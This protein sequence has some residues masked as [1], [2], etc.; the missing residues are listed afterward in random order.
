VVVASQEAVMTDLL[1]RN[2]IVVTSDSSGT[3]IP[4]GAVAVE[5]SRISAVGTAAEL[6]PLAE[7]A[8]RVIDGVGHILMPGIVNTH[9]HAADSLFR[10][11]V[12]DLPL[13]PWLQTVWKAEGAIL[14]PET[15][16]LGSVLGFA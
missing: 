1:I 9:C 15:S 6:S 11:L 5:G 10:G 3:V 2:A 14:N 13:E 4:D 7:R 12:E 16:R 8:Q